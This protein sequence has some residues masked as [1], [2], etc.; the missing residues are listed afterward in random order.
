MNL[1]LMERSLRRKYEIVSAQTGEQ[2]LT[3]L[4]TTD[5][6]AVIL[7]DYKMPEMNGAELLAEAMSTHPHVKRVVITGYADADSVIEAV[8][9][10]HIDY[11]IKKPW[12]HRELHQIIEQLV[13]SYQLEDRNRQLVAKLQAADGPPTDTQTGHEDPPTK[14][15][16]RLRAGPAYR[17]E[18]T[19]LYTRRVF[20]DRLREEIARCRRHGHTLSLLYGD[21]DNLAEINK[22][23][24][25]EA[26][27]QVLCRI[28]DV[29]TSAESEVRC[30]A[31]DV[32][33]RYDGQ[34]F[35]LLLPETPKAGALTKA[36]RL[37]AAIAD[38]RVPGVD[39]MTV[40]FG[41]AAF[42][43]DASSA[44]DLVSC[45]EQANAV[46]KQAGRDYVHLYGAATTPQTPPSIKLDP[47]SVRDTRTFY[48][49]N[50]FRS[51]YEELPRITAIL[52]RDRA[53]SGLYVDVSHL[54]RIELEHGGLIHSE[55]YIKAG[56]ILSA[57][58][59]EELA[60]GDLV[61]RTEE[62]DGYLCI[63]SA[64]H[65]KRSDMSLEELAD[66]VQ[67]RLVRAVMPDVYD[68]SHRQ[69][70]LSVGY[71]QVLHNS[72]LRPERQI[73]RL[74]SEARASSDVQRNRAASLDKT[75]LQ[76]IIL[77][78]GLSP[79]YQPIV[80]LASGEL[81]GFEALT[82]GPRQTSLE[83]PASL[84]TVAEE[85]GLTF[86]LDRACFRTALRGAMGLEP[87]HRLFV[88]LLPLS[89]Y[90][91]SFIETEV[92]NLLDAAAL[93]PAN[94]VFEITEQ[95]AI[96][97]FTSFREILA[98]YTAMGFGVAIDDVGTRHSNL[99]SVMSLRPHLIKISDVLTRGVAR[100]PVKR[101]MLKSLNRIAEAIDA[102]VVAE[103]IETPDDLV[104]LHDLNVR[105]G[106]GYFLSRPG[107]PFP[108]LRASVRRA[109][110]AMANQP[111][112]PLASPPA[113]FD[114]HG[115][116]RE[117]TRAG[118]EINEVVKAMA[119]ANEPQ[120][121]REPAGFATMGHDESNEPSEDEFFEETKPH[122]SAEHGVWEPF[123]LEDLGLSDSDRG[124]PLIENLLRRKP[125]RPK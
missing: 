93:T 25:Y 1:E 87:V 41:I 43:D 74:V 63:L 46:A 106:Q 73:A 109:V 118:S 13:H 89:F 28:T 64:E 117:A 31:S 57:M 70:R 125:T 103:G 97:N 20:R 101:E 105:Y 35:T 38:E 36:Q 26:G 9:K 11:L 104:V 6:I 82:R 45:A 21:V 76:D 56:L 61:C 69:P 113:D 49:I 10:G 22:Q 37:R 67:D 27:N 120:T 90:D 86:E 108:Q 7:S 123:S 17:D 19:G 18:L 33:G 84:F 51:Y 111:R 80:H 92:S 88:N 59:G 44:D 85:V 68:F 77:N 116:F 65:A 54:R 50:R 94:V 29:M 39:R 12:R 122:V 66:R 3:L 47:G 8:N 24:G 23:L 15:Q 42:P 96:E 78:N 100:S 14:E 107:P 30:R 52:R 53:V 75:F 124:V 72:M 5:D 102:V 121:G 2:A 16:P 60:D 99:E 34:I 4:R 58:R 55:L 62:D 95:L 112:K 91:S 119:S 81:F 110:L 40:S 98:R 83:T 71:A 114:E 48:D 115:E 32:V 79:V